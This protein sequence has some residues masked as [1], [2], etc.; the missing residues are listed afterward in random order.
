MEEYIR[1]EEEKAQKHGLTFNWQTTT[2]GKGKNY[3]DED[4]CFTD[5]ETEFPAIVFDNPITS[6]TSLPYEPM[7]SSTN[8]NKINFRISLDESDDEDYTVIFD[9]NSF[10]Y[11]IISV[12][13]LKTDSENDKILK[14]SSSEPTV[15][16]LD[17][18]DYFDDFENEF[19]AIVYNDGL[20][21]KPDPEIEPPVSSEHVSKYETSLSKYNEEEQ[22]V[23]HFSNSFPLDEIFSNDPKMI[24]D[25]DIARPYMAPLPT[26]DQR[27]PWL[28]YQVEGYTEDIVHNYEQRLE[29]IWGRSVNQVHVLDFDDLTPD[30]RQDLAVRLR[31]VYTRGDEQLAFVSH[32]W[33]R[34][35]EIQAPLVREFILEFLSTCMM[36]DTEMGLDEM[37][38]AGFGA[39]WAGSDRVIPDKGD[40][41]DYW[42]EI[43]SD[44]DFLGP[45]PSY[46]TEKVTGVD[47]FYLRNM[48]RGTANVSHLLA[49]YL[50]RHAEERK[51]E[52]RLS[53]GHFIGRL[54]LHFRL[55][56]D[57][58]LRGL[59][60]WVAPRLERQQV[61]AAG[62]HEADETG[63]AVGE[64]AQEVPAPVQAPLPAPQPRTMSQRIDRIEEDMHE[65]RQIVMGLRGVVESSI[66]E[67][68]RVST[69]MISCMTQLM[70]ASGR[71][72]QAFDN[73][74]VGS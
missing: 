54:A 30:M 33:R 66:T 34:L 8:E 31:M 44:K 5:F 39:Y 6:D 56:S 41:R 24:K 40:L 13:D 65:L 60:A 10:S 48:D 7:V 22:N 12:N 15:N 36:S 14:P 63:P 50:F 42:I 27:H 3:E 47:L 58:G 62:A 26:A 28:R 52:A 61:A 45:A 25:S 19:P 43:L 21:S 11:K 57:E 29:T 55:V 46:S 51:S 38:E 23:L 32:A 16:Y 70:D 1:L 35:F 49:Q 68:T 71:T 72:Y 20:T 69:W 17:D 2:L 37:A 18:L 9:E 4:D 59:Q 67:Q 73:T 53:G 74:L 64:G